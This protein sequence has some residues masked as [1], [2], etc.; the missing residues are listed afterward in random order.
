M[1]TFIETEGLPGIYGPRI[2][3]ENKPEHKAILAVLSKECVWG[4]Y[5]WSHR[6]DQTMVEWVGFEFPLGHDVSSAMR[7]ARAMEALCFDGFKQVLAE[8]VMSHFR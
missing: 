5:V 8:E 6:H 2:Y 3:V 1:K 4:S 7:M